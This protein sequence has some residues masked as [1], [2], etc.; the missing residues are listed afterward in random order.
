MRSLTLFVE[1]AL[2]LVFGA[3]GCVVGHAA[4]VR[5]VGRSSATCL[6][7]PWLSDLAAA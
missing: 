5:F 6:V 7:S 2:V 3:A 4:Y 1:S